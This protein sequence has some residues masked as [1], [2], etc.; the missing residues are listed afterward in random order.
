M[1][2]KNELS[3]TKILLFVLKIFPFLRLD[4]KIEVFDKLEELFLN[5]ENKYRKM[6]AY[7][8]KNWLKKNYINYTDISEEEFIN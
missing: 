4:D 2:K 8:K 1:C 6:I 7:Y 3:T 5:S